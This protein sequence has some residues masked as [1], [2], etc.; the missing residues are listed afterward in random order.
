VAKD[1]NALSAL[2]M[3]YV[4]I[5]MISVQQPLNTHQTMQCNV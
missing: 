1:I 3:T 2:T 4:R 5:V